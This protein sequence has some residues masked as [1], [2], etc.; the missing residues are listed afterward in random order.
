MHSFLTGE[1]FRNS[2]G[3][4]GPMP[5][6]RNELEDFN[7]TSSLFS[8]GGLCNEDAMTLLDKIQILSCPVPVHHPTVFGSSRFL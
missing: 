1:I 8:T 6:A 4:L 2:G 3:K 7:Q 5:Y